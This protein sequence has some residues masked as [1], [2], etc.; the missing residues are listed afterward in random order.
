[1]PPA[2]YSPFFCSVFGP[3]FSFDPFPWPN[4]VCESTRP[5]EWPRPSASL[6]IFLSFFGYWTLDC[7]PKIGMDLLCTTRPLTWPWGDVDTIAFVQSSGRHE[8]EGAFLHQPK[9]RK[10]ILVFSTPQ[11]RAFPNQPHCGQV[12]FSSSF[13]LSSEGLIDVEVFKSLLSEIQFS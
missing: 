4:P 8:E 1:M 11:C 3:P 2:Q 10:D 12:Y 9:S 5:S 7:A 6:R 13:F